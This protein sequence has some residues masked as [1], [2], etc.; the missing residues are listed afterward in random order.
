MFYE[1]RQ[2]NSGGSFDFD[3]VNGITH[4]V[5]I[6]AD[7]VED[8]NTKAHEIGIYFDGVGKGYDCSCCGDRWY[9]PWPSKGT[10]LLEVNGGHPKDFDKLEWST[11]LMKPG[12]EICVHYKDGTKEWF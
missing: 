5:V 8:A 1:Y 3:E 10:E 9:E 2:N 11:R 7:N 12:K 4:Y 6:E